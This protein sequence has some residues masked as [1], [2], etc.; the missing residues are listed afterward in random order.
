MPRLSVCGIQF[1]F[2]VKTNYLALLCLL[3]SLTMAAQPISFTVSMDNPAA[4]YFRVVMQ[5]HNLAGKT[6]DLKMPVWTP[7]YYQRL[8]FARNLDS[9]AV[10]GENGRALAWEKTDDNTWRVHSNDAATLTVAY[11]INTR[12][13]FVATPFLDSTRGYISPA[14]VFLHPAGQLHQPV[15]VIIQPFR[16]WKNVATGLDTVA[17]KPFTY[18]ASDYDMLY[19]CPILTGN[20]EELPPFTVS[21]IP[22]RFIAYNPGNFDKAQFTNDL[23][24]IVKTASAIIGH[25]PYKQYTF[26]A[27]GPGAGGIEHANSTTISFNGAALHS[28]EG[29]LRL[30]NFIAHEYFHHYNVKRIRP[31]ELGPFDYDNG[32]RTKMLWVSEGLTV[33]YEYLILKRAGIAAEEDLFRNIRSNIT[34]FE[35]KTGKLHQSLAEASYETWRDGPFGRTGDSV[36]KTISYYDKGPVVGMLFD[37]AIRHETNNQKSLDD[38]MRRLYREFYQQKKRGFTEE[39]LREV[40]ESTAGTK[41]DELFEYIYTTREINYRKYLAYAGLAMD[42]GYQLTRMQHPDALQAS[43][44]KTWLGEK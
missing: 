3:L 5:C 44:L 30:L 40:V 35:T 31:I 16:A 41:L 27:I 26:I 36:N 17:G 1:S 29:R 25:I 9:F 43:I 34:A 33:Y 10:T 4:H 42:S 12:R 6:I 19:D 7:G 2:L 14:G 39:E 8:N 15:Q 37:F 18:A 11:I 21:G 28:P 38:V 20:L 22:H 32:N 13:A 24:K 23:K